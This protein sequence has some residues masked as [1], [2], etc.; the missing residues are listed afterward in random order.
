MAPSAAL[1]EQVGDGVEVAEEELKALLYRPQEGEWGAHTRDEECER[2]IQGIDQI[3]T[4]GKSPHRWQHFVCSKG[5]LTWCSFTPC[6]STEVAKAFASPVNLRDYPL[7]CTVVAYPTD[8]STIRKRLENRFY[9]WGSMRILS[10]VLSWIRSPSAT[11]LTF[12]LHVQMF[13]S[14]A[15]GSLR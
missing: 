6:V 4:L 10:D 3:L 15:G 9:R 2:V 1:P 13:F 11:E 8:L 7:Y 14:A 5:N 12:E